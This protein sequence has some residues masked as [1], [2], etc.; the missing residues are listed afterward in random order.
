MLFKH[1]RASYQET[2]PLRDPVFDFIVGVYDI[3]QQDSLV[4]FQ[5]KARVV[6]VNYPVKYLWWVWQEFLPI[7]IM[8]DEFWNF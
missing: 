2:V 3:Y 4:S 5:G 8:R 7:D 1:L 6:S